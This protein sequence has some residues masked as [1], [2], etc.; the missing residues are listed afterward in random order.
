[1][2]QVVTI[3]EGDKCTCCPYGYHVDL[4]FVN[5]C[6]T[7]ADGSYL[8]KLKRIQREKRK[9]RKSMEFFLQQQENQEH[10]SPPP[11]L[12]QNVNVQATAF[13]KNI[14]YKD[15]ATNK[16]LEEIDSSVDQTLHSIDSM[17]YTTKAHSQLVSSDDDISPSSN[18]NFNTFPMSKS[19]KSQNVE[20]EV[21]TRDF[22]LRELARSDS[23][24]SLSSISTMASDTYNLVPVKV[25][26]FAQMTGGGST[27]ENNSRFTHITTEELEYTMATHLPTEE[28]TTTNI[29][30]SSVE[31]V[32]K[33]MESSLQRI[34]EL[35]EQVKAIPVLQVRI[36]VLKEEKRLLMLQQKARNQKLNTRTIGVG[37][38]P[39]IPPPSPKSPPP[40]LPKPKVK[41]VGVGDHNIIEVYLLQPDLSPTCTIHD[42]EKFFSETTVIERDHYQGVFAPFAKHLPKPP[43]RTVGI[44]EGNVFDDGLRI[45]EKELRTV[46]IGKESV[47]KRN[48][49]VDCR[50]ATRDV[51]MNFSLDDEKPATRSVGVN[52]DSEAWLT[53]LNVKASEVRKAMQEALHRSVRTVGVSCDLKAQTVETGVQYTH[54]HFRSIGVGDESV[55][56][57]QIP[58][59]TVGVEA[60]P[61]TM[62][63]AANT[64]YG[65]KVDSA[66]NTVKFFTDNK[67]VQSER[68]LQGTMS[69]MTEGT[70]TYH[71]TTQTEHRIFLALNMVKNTECNT[72][73]KKKKTV[74]CDTD[75]RELT[76]ADYGFHITFRGRNINSYDAGCNTE[77]KKMC[78]VGVGEGKIEYEDEPMMEE[79]T[80]EVTYVTQT[81]IIEAAQQNLAR[82]KQITRTY[83]TVSSADR[84]ALTKQLLEKGVV[85]IPQSSVIIQEISSSEGPMDIKTEETHQSL[86]S[87]CDDGAMSSESRTSRRMYSSARYGTV[88]NDNFPGLTDKNETVVHSSSNF[89]SGGSSDMSRFDV[90]DMLKEQENS[91]QGSESLVEKKITSQGGNTYSVTTIT[92]KKHSE[93]NEGGEET[94]LDGGERLRVLTGRATDQSGDSSASG[95]Y[96]VARSTMSY[97]GDSSDSGMSSFVKGQSSKGLDSDSLGELHMT[98]SESSSSG[99]DTSNEDQEE[100]H[101]IT[102]TYSLR[103]IGGQS[104][105]EKY[106]KSAGM[107][108]ENTAGRRQDSPDLDTM[109]SISSGSLKSCMKKSKSENGV[110]RGITFAE[111]VTGGYVKSLLCPNVKICLSHRLSFFLINKFMLG[112]ALE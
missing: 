77:R 48:V 55:E 66:T 75:I 93:D 62:S 31:T 45:H 22:S 84:S 26:G 102:E 69:T 24:E 111:T 98:S 36:S 88:S 7:L 86:G 92:T 18:Q 5:Y 50:V 35:E 43:T 39:V 78:S 76:N 71:E 107:D 64:D 110:R 109:D 72:E 59:R 32:R 96:R 87:Q 53:N 60:Q 12:V 51:G 74:S 46:I 13:L 42:N 20:D 89:G 17:M 80:E 52:V 57:P 6:E 4:D 9:L 33:T 23:K 15:S 34:R 61:E 49:G 40:T 95:M 47:G 30:K 81:Q 85:E 99:V 79:T 90:S 38:S 25:T 21:I 10:S 100:V 14:E 29:S 19:Y 63:K 16:V 44:G 2:Q 28:S 101:V 83:G 56:K 3:N 97:D 82:G 103:D 73:E 8:T 41:S 58:T 108:S 94:L 37:E 65:W 106:I 1:M 105:Y 27:S 68:T 70:R 67:G 11:D 91:S 54:Q 104:Y 112:T